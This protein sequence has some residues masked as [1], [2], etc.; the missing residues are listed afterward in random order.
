MGEVAVEAGR[1]DAA[2]DGS[3]DVMVTQTCGNYVI[4]GTE[5]CDRDQLRGSTCA[6]LGVGSPSGVL[7]CN[8]TCSG[9]DTS[10]CGQ[11]SGDGGA[12]VDM[13]PAS[14][15]KIPLAQILADG[16]CSTPPGNVSLTAGFA[17]A[18]EIAYIVPLGQ[19]A[20][21][22]VTPT[23][24]LYIYYPSQT[25]GPAGNYPIVSPAAG[26]IRGVGKLD[27]DYRVIIEHSCDVWS[28]YIHVQTLT[29]PLAAIAGQVTF[30]RG[31]FGSIPI[32]A[33]ETFAT[34]GA[35]PG[36][37]YSLFDQRVTLK[38]LNPASYARS[39]TWKLH[40]VDP[41]DYM[42]DP[43]KSQLLAKNLRGA[44]P[45][46]GKIDF[47]APGVATGNW[48]VV[49]TNG[50][51]GD[52]RN[53][54]TGPITPG[55]HRGYW[56]THLALVPDPID[57]THFIAS[58]GNF[59]GTAVQYA[60]EIDPATLTVASGPTVLE[61]H[62][63]SYYKPDGMPFSQDVNN[64]AYAAGVTVKPSDTTMGVLLVQ[65]LPDGTLKVEKRPGATASTSTTFGADVL[66]YQ[67]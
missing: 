13:A 52:P 25:A 10:N 32:A 65:L 46:G 54:P 43:L 30:Q 12:M 20:F 45:R 1:D 40:T 11:S 7:K 17:N 9:W 42:T 6:S 67:H 33:G 36:Y 64:A 57:P 8:S 3:T 59:G 66:I 62:S 63:Y 16:Q 28:V 5:V 60:I 2:P 4:E 44:A 51:A 38:G 34:D 53:N 50:Y 29:G 37:D 24:H 21:G 49:G 31:W 58:V 22:H 39:E 26:R 41:F 18:T 19:M 48:F 14:A 35:Q 27:S 55:Q 56:D 23:D 61:L 15:D 47:D